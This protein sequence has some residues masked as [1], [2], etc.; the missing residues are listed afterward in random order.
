MYIFK[1]LPSW[2][3]H[4]LN[5]SD[6]KPTKVFF[7]A[8]TDGGD[9]IIPTET[10]SNNPSDSFEPKINVSGNSVHV[11]WTELQALLTGHDIFFRRSTDDGDSF[12]PIINLS[13]NSG[14]ST[15][16]EMSTSGTDVY[17][18]WQDTDPGNNEIFFRRSTVNGDNF[19]ATQNISDSAG[20]SHTPQLA[21][22]IG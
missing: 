6:E 15:V 18:V 1:P 2:L 11:I 14:N 9:N 19:D 4:Y 12:G 5:S 20:I 16:P 22:T 10:L 21:S 13:D 8:S 17:V 7:R 3:I